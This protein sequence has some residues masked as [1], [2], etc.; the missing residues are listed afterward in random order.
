MQRKELPFEV[1]QYD[2]RTI[3]GYAAAFGNVD[4]V[5]DIIHPGAFKK[6]LSE[7][8]QQVKFLW[9][10]DTKIP[11][12]KPLELREE[13]KGLFM[14]AII[15]DMAQGRDALA[16]LADGAIDGLSIGYD[17]VRSDASTVSTDGGD[18]KAVRNLRE[19][20]LYEVSLCTFPA[21]Q[22]AGVTAVKSEEDKAEWTA[23]VINDLPDSAFLYVGDGGEK[24]DGKTTPRTLRKFPVRDSEGA[25]DLPHLRN[26]L[27]RIPQSDLSEDEQATL[28]GKAQGLLDT[29][30]D[31]PEPEEDKTGKVLSAS[32]RSKL[33]GA[34]QQA[35]EAV[36]TIGGVLTIG[37]TDAVVEEDEPDEEKAVNLTSRVDQVRDAFLTV[38]TP[39]GPYTDGQNVNRYWP[40]TV[41]DEYLIAQN[42]RSNK[43][44]RVN[45]T[46][47]A[48]ENVIFDPPTDWVSGK[49]EFVASEP[50]TAEPPIK[51]APT[52][53][54]ES[55]LQEIEIVNVSLDLLGG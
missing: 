30:K 45:Y 55:T 35:R 20:K 26:A 19:L 13:A 34:M 10:H 37:I 7:R 24:A 41:Y 48:D 27:A 2:G 6:T 11:L 38:Y 36:D 1:T 54:W 8:G 15:S 40:A 31:A 5:N 21:N 44:Y 47:D 29:E 51:S 32:T 23:A 33:E 22:S 16:L 42:E 46:M 14:R 3:E 53:D 52:V 25:I 17:T 39:T 28:T 50:E 4:L 43:Y 12:G 9:Q 49:M 18:T